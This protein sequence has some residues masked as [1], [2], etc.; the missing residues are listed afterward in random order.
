MFTERS[1]PS[2]SSR[3]KQ[4]HSNLGKNTVTGRLSMCKGPGAGLSLM[5]E[6]RMEEALWLQQREMGA[7]EG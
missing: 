3:V 6:R 7:M 2:E 4:P 5:F 1:G